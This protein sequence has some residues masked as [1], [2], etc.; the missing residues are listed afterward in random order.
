MG[1][2]TPPPTRSTRPAA[3]KTRSGLAA[4]AVQIFFPVVL[5]AVLSQTFVS[6]RFILVFVILTATDIS[7][8]AAH[9]R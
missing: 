5:K 1:R 6:N 8:T 2:L 4:A 3:P 9:C 7:L